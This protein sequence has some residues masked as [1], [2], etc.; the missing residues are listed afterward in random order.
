MRLKRSVF[1]DPEY[2][3]KTLIAFKTKK[4][5]VSDRTKKI[6]FVLPPPNF[7]LV[8]LD[9]SAFAL[10]KIGSSAVKLVARTVRNAAVVLPK[11]FSFVLPRVH[12]LH[13]LVGYFHLPIC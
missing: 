6:P 1:F 12:L 9:F 5:C 4:I 11:N 2:N 3:R 13:Y 8:L 7:P 10:D